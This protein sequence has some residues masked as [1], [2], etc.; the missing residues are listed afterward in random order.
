MFWFFRDGG[1]SNFAFFVAIHIVIFDQNSKDVFVGTTCQQYAFWPKWTS[2]SAVSVKN[3]HFLS[4]L[5]WFSSHGDIFSSLRKCLG[6]GLGCLHWLGRAHCLHGPTDLIDAF[7][8]IDSIDLMDFI[9][10]IDFTA[11]RATTMTMATTNKAVGALH[12][13]FERSHCQ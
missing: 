1:A 13:R 5:I 12:N 4:R 6:H 7:D 11:N 8:Q 9:V 2:N 10:L 3:D